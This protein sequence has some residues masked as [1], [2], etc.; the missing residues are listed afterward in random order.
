MSKDY[1]LIIT[2][3]NI[4]VLILGISLIIF[5]IETAKAISNIEIQLVNQT[6]NNRDNRW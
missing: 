1:K 4:T 2:I 6:E 5:Q 3:M